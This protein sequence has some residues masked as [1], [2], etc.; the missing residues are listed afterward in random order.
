MLSALALA[1][2]SADMPRRIS[3]LPAACRSV[4]AVPS[5]AE[6]EALRSAA[7]SKKVTARK[8]LE[9][10]LACTSIVEIG[11]NIG[12]IQFLGS[13]NAIQIS[14]GPHG[15]S[16]QS[17]RGGRRGGK[18]SGFWRPVSIPPFA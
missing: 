18:I 11:R 5:S 10:S 9:Q 14:G 8:C 6:T 2:K 12:V 7:R 13:Q 16:R 3:L 1:E 17:I 15:R 4:L